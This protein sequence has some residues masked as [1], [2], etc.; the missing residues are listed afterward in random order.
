MKPDRQRIVARTGRVALL[1]LSRDGFDTW[2]VRCPDS[3]G[4]LTYFTQSSEA[5]ARDFYCRVTLALAK[6]I[7]ETNG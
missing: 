7:G 6:Q 2:A 5:V 3:F 4:R 1:I